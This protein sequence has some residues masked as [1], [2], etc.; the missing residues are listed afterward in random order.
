[1][2]ITSGGAVGNAAYQRANWSPVGDDCW[3]IGEEGPVVDLT[4]FGAKPRPVADA[5][6][7]K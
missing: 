4:N 7:R 6:P 1:M 2:G 3:G 5:D